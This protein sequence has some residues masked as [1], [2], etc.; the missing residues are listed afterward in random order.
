M[1]TP[2]A[3]TADEARSLLREVIH[4]RAKYRARRWIPTTPASG[5]TLNT[6]PEHR[7]RRSNRASQSK[8]RRW[9]YSDQWPQIRTKFLGHRVTQPVNPNNMVFGQSS[10]GTG[11]GLQGNGTE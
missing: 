10:F 8:E 2:R 3:G 1:Y 6:L 7:E 5:E 9:W 4:N 11:H